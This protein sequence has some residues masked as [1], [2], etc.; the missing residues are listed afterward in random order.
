MTITNSKPELMKGLRNKFGC[1]LKERDF[2]LMSFVYEYNEDIN[3]MEDREKPPKE[4]YHLIYKRL[5]ICVKIDLEYIQKLV[6]L[7]EPDYKIE[8]VRGKVEIGKPF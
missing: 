2:N 7:I 8:V 3:K 4:N 5:N 1:F 6:R